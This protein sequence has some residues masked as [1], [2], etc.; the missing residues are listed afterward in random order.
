MHPSRRNSRT[1]CRQSKGNERDQPNDEDGSI[2]NH[3]NNAL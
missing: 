2:T 3:E 1:G